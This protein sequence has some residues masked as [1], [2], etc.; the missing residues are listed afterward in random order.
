M[1]LG[2]FR[3]RQKLVLM[4]MVV[5]MVAFLVPSGIR[6]CFERHPQ[7]EVIGWA[8]EKKITLAM[9]WTADADIKIL[10][11]WLGLGRRGLPGEGAFV[12]FQM[13]NE[14]QQP[15]LAWALLLHEARQMGIRTTEGEVDSFLAAAGL[16]GEAYQQL[17]SDLSRER[18]GEKDLRRAVASHLTIMGALAAGIV[19]VPPSLPEVRTTYRD[20]RERIQLGMVVLKAEDFAQAAAE[21]TEAEISEFFAQ[22]N[23]VLPDAPTNR[24]ED[25]FGYR[26]PDRADVAWLFIDQERLAEAVTV[27]EPLMREYWLRHKDE[28]TREVPLPTTATAP[29]ATQPAQT[30]ATQL[31]EP[32]TQTVP[33][34]KYSEAKP[35]IREKLRPLVAEQKLA[36]LIVQA[37]QLIARHAD[38]RDP[39]QRAFI[40]LTG[41]AET[42]L[43]R[44]VAYLPPAAAPLETV[45]EQLENIT[46]VKIAFPY[47][48]HEKLNIDPKVVVSLDRL[49]GSLTLKQVLAEVR[50][51][52]KLPD[53][54][55][56]KTLKGLEDAIFPTEP[57]NLLPVRVGRTGPV[58]LAQLGRQEPLGWA[59]TAPGGGESLKDIVATAEVFHAPET[60]HTPLIEVGRDFRQ[61]M[62]VTWPA[63]GRLLWRLMDAE[64][65]HEPTEITPAIRAQVIQDLKTNR[66]LAKAHDAARKMLAQLNADKDLEKLAKDAK[67]QFIK[68][69]PF[70]RKLAVPRRGIGGFNFVVVPTSVPEA[71]SNP[72]FLKQAF[73]LAPADPDDR[74]NPGP[75]DIVLLRRVHKLLLIQRIGYDPPTNEEFDKIGLYLTVPVVMAQ[76]RE[77]GLI[78]WFA[79][80]SIKDRLGF[81]FKFAGG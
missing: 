26:Q 6:G 37:Q 59:S 1:A 2:F 24:W 19:T 16:S 76:R 10:S 34:E 79:F 72:E 68:T 74:T 31:A 43:E 52:L 23:N 17:L 64:A 18:L 30:Q 61:A 77:A 69:D 29:A 67:L 15:E 70:A 12:L 71:G 27:P 9:Q 56:W 4:V 36:E 75:A 66:G 58:E 20:L 60:R 11:R 44:K 8:G 53:P 63:T 51:A 42:L 47:G 78:T 49:K 65:E 46:G 55:T 62:Y 45:L 22:R 41:D 73:A 3:R 50:L 57:V 81:R 39:Y 32:K 38:D 21:P 54:F 48:E 28:L 13:I 80:D 14:G 25:G 5:L 7:K 40:A 35:L 33:I